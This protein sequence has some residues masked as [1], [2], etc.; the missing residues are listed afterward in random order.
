MAKIDNI[1]LNSDELKSEEKYGKFNEFVDADDTFAFGDEDDDMTNEMNS[2]DFGSDSYAFNADPISVDPISNDEPASVDEPADSILLDS[3]MPEF[4]EAGSDDLNTQVDNAPEEVISTENVSAPEEKNSN[5]ELNSNEEASSPSAEE[6][7]AES[8]ARQE[9]IELINQSMKAEKKAEAIEDDEEPVERKSFSD[10]DAEEGVE[11]VI[12]DLFPEH[13]SVIDLE[14]SKEQKKVKKE[15]A[16]E[17][18][19][20]TPKADEEKE[21]KKKKFPF[22]LLVAILAGVILIA[23]GLWFADSK[24]HFISSSPKDSTEE[25]QLKRRRDFYDDRVSKAAKPKVDTAA[26]DSAKA[27]QDSILA[28]QRRIQDSIETAELRKQIEQEKKDI[29]AAEK[30]AKQEEIKAKKAAAAEKS[31]ELKAKQKA[32]K[33]SRKAQLANMKAERAA[34][35]KA[36]HE[37]K[38]K[39]EKADKAEKN[40]ALRAER[41]RKIAEAK[42]KK[43]AEKAKIEESK[44]AKQESQRSKKETPKLAKKEQSIAKKQETDNI[45]DAEFTVQVYASP[46][47]EDAVNWLN[48]VNRKVGGQATM[49]TQIKRDVKWYRIRFGIFKS[50]EEAEDA[51]RKAG[52]NQVW[53]DRV[54]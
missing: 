12:D 10:T 7:D 27:A 50:R 43:E 13:P 38:I 40:K 37:E 3:D 24:L 19:A 5:E 23:G 18:K 31:R 22:L 32:E 48:K 21:E 46:S 6:M 20:E 39:A 54:K 28:E 29:A 45:K 17:V 35:L 26:Q 44:R 15:K 14:K 16:T 9:L 8:K 25:A 4:S 53:I 49:S 52:F 41:D 42:A 36:E 47:R 11:I 34:K 30:L 2:L 1:G 33:E 51:A